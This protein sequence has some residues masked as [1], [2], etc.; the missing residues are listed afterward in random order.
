MAPVAK[1]DPPMY[2]IES[3]DNA[4]RLL[5]TFRE[6]PSLRVAEASRALGVAPSTA[7]RLL[8][9]LQYHGFVVQDPKSKAYRA[10]AALTDIG[11]AVVRNMDVRALARPAMESLVKELGETVHLGMLD[12]DEVLFLDSIEGSQVVRVGSRIG[13][14]LP[15]HTTSLG[16]AMLAHLPTERLLELYPSETLPARTARSTDRREVL[17]RALAQVAEQ[18]YA[19]NEC[20]SEEDVCGVGV[21]IL[22]P[23]GTPAAAISVSTPQSRFSEQ[24]VKRALPAL[25][26]AAAEVRE[27]L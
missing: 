3:V 20:E 7:H 25:R 21:A 26:E 13:V 15:A 4:L 18:G 27:A 23:A 1:P 10:G 11:L 19:V 22:T 16:K 5:L 8:A 6:Q 2:P 9:M 17:L 14:R 12:R 24:L